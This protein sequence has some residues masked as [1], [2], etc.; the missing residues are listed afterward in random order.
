MKQ[1]DKSNV[2]YTVIF[3]IGL[4]ILIG[5]VLITLFKINIS[6]GFLGLAFILMCIGALGVEV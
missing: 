4:L 6:L 2:I 3:L 1:K 5:V